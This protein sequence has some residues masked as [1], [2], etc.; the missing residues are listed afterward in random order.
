MAP[1]PSTS[2]TA[3]TLCAISRSGRVQLTDK[4]ASVDVNI[5]TNG[6]GTFEYLAATIQSASPIAVGDDVLVG[7]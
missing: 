5:D 7:S 1:I 4:G 6:D 3:T 2:P